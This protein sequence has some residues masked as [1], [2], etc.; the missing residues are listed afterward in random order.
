VNKIT[1]KAR[2]DRIIDAIRKWAYLHGRPPRV[3][4]WSHVSSQEFLEKEGDWPS[5]HTAIRYSPDGTWGG[6]LELAGYDRPS[7]GRPSRLEGRDDG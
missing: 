1:F 4:D 6:I 7:R 2:Q 5:Y 3:A